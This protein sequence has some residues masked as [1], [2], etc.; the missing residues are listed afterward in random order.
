MSHASCR[1]CGTAWDAGERSDGN[2]YIPD[3]PVCERWVIRT[4]RDAEAAID[5]LCE[6]VSDRVSGDVLERWDRHNDLEKAIKSAI[7]IAR[8]SHAE[9]SE[10]EKGV[11]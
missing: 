5:A 10:G 7:E 4:E 8:G 1:D 9:K 2:N 11:D 6:F 3:C